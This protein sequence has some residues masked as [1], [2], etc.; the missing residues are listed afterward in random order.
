[1]Y[2]EVI[3]Y[4]CK[5]IFLFF[6]YISTVLGLMYVVNLSLR[7]NYINVG[8][9]K[10][11]VVYDLASHTSYWFINTHNKSA[12]LLIHRS[13]VR[14]PDTP[15]IKSRHYEKSKAFFIARGTLA[16]QFRI[17]NRNTMG[18]IFTKKMRQPQPSKIAKLNAIAVIIY[19]WCDLR[20]SG[21]DL[22]G[23]KKVS[24]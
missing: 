13:G 14:V 18:Q 22:T 23:S 1:M 6:I 8:C 4:I 16:R 5:L 9:S 7:C 11:V 3:L 2:L 21:L 24:I 15:P 12:V 10:F 20:N 17:T 19:L